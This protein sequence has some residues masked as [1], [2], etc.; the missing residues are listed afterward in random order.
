MP[1]A[2][3]VAAGAVHLQ[4]LLLPQ[5][6]SSR[7]LQGE[8]LAACLTLGLAAGVAA[9]LAGAQVP[10]RS[11]VCPQALQQRR[12]LC[13]GRRR[14]FLFGLGFDGR[15]RLRGSGRRRR[16]SRSLISGITIGCRCLKATRRERWQRRCRCR[17]GC[18]G[19]RCGI[20]RD[21]NRDFFCGERQSQRP[22]HQTQPSK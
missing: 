8:G 14:R 10:C 19:L 15:C 11:V 12:W 3:G 4:A 6:A 13:L 21:G 18:C 22:A 5:A 1:D 20:R 16:S 9:G 2:S 17:I 7:P